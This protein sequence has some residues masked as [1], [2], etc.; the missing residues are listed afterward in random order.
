MW[1]NRRKWRKKE[2]EGEKTP[3]R[4]RYIQF[5]HHVCC[6]CVIQS[7]QNSESQVSWVTR[8]LNFLSLYHPDQVGNLYISPN[9]ESRSLASK[10]VFC[11][12]WFF[13]FFAEAMEIHLNVVGWVNLFLSSQSSYFDMI[14]FFVKSSSAPIEW[15][16][17]MCLDTTSCL[18]TGNEHKKAI[19]SVVKLDALFSQQMAYLIKKLLSQDF[20]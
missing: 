19:V 16:E 20:T 18:N 14:F 11:L 1:R 15:G 7:I 17:T 6:W 13:F 5:S 10:Q 2:E 8:S 3:K 9:T 4:T 12:P